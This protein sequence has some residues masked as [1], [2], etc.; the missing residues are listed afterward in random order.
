MSHSA[1]TTAP[2]GVK[3][4]RWLSLAGACPVSDEP[5]A[6][7]R[8]PGANTLRKIEVWLSLAKTFPDHLVSSWVSDTPG[9]ASYSH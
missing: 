4:E 3:R 8:E 6:S 9:D 5:P 1:K 7:E 2:R